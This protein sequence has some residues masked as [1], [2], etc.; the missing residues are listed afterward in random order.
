MIFKKYLFEKD[1]ADR[2]IR[3]LRLATGSLVLAVILQG[4]AIKS[5][6]GSEKVVITPPEINKSFWV[7]GTRVSKEYLEEMA[8]W[9][10]GLALNVTP[11]TSEYQNRL[12]LNYAAPSDYGRLQA[13]I[14]A[15]A[16]RLKKANAS[17]QF[18]VRSMTTDEENLRVT[19]SGTLY[20]WVS[21]KR[22]GNRGTSY[23]VGFKKLNGRLYVADFKETSTR[24]PFG[25]AAAASDDPGSLSVPDSD[26]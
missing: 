5:M 11:S 7:S 4:I 19:L 9:Y 3:F 23:M 1:N 25:D 10:A 6:I 13:E 15:Q 24:D 22:A 8:Y 26:G 17:T 18:S 2:E 14:G 20:T 21:D 12:F 16:A